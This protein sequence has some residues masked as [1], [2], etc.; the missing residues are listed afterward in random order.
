[1]PLDTS[2]FEKAVDSLETALT[3]YTNA[4]HP[5]G[6]AERELMRDGVIQRFE[7]T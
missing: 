6:S 2:S 7:Y 4:P 5:K 1:M 3:A